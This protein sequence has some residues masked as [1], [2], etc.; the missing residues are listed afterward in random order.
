MGYEVEVEKWSSRVREQ[1]TNF[2]SSRDMPL[3]KDK[4]SLLLSLSFSPLLLLSL[5]SLLPLSLHL[6]FFL[7]LL[8]F[9]FLFLSPGRWI[10][11]EG[12]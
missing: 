4:I 10:L 11:P 7:F 1:S 5:S 3:S 2:R 9:L 12:L 8:V 6:L